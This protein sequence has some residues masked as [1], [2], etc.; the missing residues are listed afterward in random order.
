[1]HKTR[2]FT[3]LTCLALA[4][5]AVLILFLVASCAGVV[6]PVSSPSRPAVTGR[7]VA[8]QNLS[9]VSLKVM[10]PD[11]TGHYG[12]GVIVSEHR[13]LTAAHVAQCAAEDVG[14]VAATSITV[15]SGGT[16]F[17]A[18]ADTIIQEAD[19]ARVKVS[20]SLKQRLSP[21]SVGPLPAV[22]DTV[23]FMS[24][25]PRYRYRCGLAQRSEPGPNADIVIEDAGVMHGN[26]GSGLFDLQGRLIGII[27]QLYPCEFSVCGGRASSLAAW[28]SLIEGA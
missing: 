21:V 18:E 4:L 20:G 16:S 6:H 15:E 27:V 24:A 14:H 9:A 2:Q 25:V 10:C 26:S 13:I 19:I 11:G 17:T 5:N 23:C 12:S 28:S 7:T 1:M 22:G 8:E 3:P